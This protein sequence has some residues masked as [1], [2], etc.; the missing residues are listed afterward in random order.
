LVEAFQ[1]LLVGLNPTAPLDDLGWL[2]EQES[3]HLAFR[4]AAAQVE[5]GAVFFTLAAMAVGAAAP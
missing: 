3:S 4:Q 2:F 5:K 1:E